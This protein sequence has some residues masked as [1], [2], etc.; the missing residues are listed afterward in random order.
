MIDASGTDFVTTKASNWPDGVSVNVTRMQKTNMPMRGT[1]DLTY[2]D[3]N[4]GPFT[5]PGMK[6]QLLWYCN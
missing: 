1:F 5:L 3:A 6:P 4:I 2:E